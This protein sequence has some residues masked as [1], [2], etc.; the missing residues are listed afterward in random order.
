MRRY[1]HT[2]RVTDKTWR[3]MHAFHGNTLLEAEK[4]LFAAF[5]TTS[6]ELEERGLIILR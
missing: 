5:G 1:L 2:I 3:I 6:V 4:S